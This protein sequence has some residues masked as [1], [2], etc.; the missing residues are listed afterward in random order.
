MTTNGEPVVELVGL[1]E[2]ALVRSVLGEKPMA[3]LD[4]RMPT[5]AAVMAKLGTAVAEWKQQQGTTARAPEGG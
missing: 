1:K 4:P 2:I 3:M 5:L